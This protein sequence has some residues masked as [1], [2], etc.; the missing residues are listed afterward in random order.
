LGQVVPPKNRMGYQMSV[1]RQW[2]EGST[3]FTRVWTFC[4]GRP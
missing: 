2:L 1:R 3:W 4:E